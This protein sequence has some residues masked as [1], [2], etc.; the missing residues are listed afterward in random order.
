MV[1]RYDRAMQSSRPL[2][3]VVSGAPASGKTTLAGRLADDGGLRL[4]SR[5][6]IKE[7]LADALGHPDSIEASRALGNGAYAAM[8]AVARRL[9]DSGVDIA[10]ESNFRH[11]QSEPELLGLASNTDARCVHCVSEPSTIRTRY[12][13][14]TE[15]RHPA[16]LDGVRHQDVMRELR[17][18]RYTP[19]DVGWPTM[20][21]ETD[22]GYRPSYD[23]LRAF[24]LDRAAG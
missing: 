16:H 12:E 1:A 17:D 19:L 6:A 23:V 22:D 2:L 14:R 24:A 13:S 21:V 9:L 18:G 5:D 3:L 4:V 11:G 15:V 10:I 8:F 7:A 20:V